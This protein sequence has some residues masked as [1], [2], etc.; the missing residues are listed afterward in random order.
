MS[1][2]GY[3]PANLDG[4][5]AAARRRVCSAVLDQTP[6]LTWWR[7]GYRRGVDVVAIDRTA[8]GISLTLLGLSPRGQIWLPRSSFKSNATEV[9]GVWHSK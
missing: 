4:L 3:A 7:L 6:Y 5:N 1:T 9:C 8:V 2:G